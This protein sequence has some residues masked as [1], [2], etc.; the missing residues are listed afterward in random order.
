MQVR[1]VPLQPHAAGR[2]LGL[3]LFF[4]VLLLA[5]CQP[6]IS[7]AA[8]VEVA[9]RV[10]TEHGVLPNAVVKAFAGYDQVTAGKPFM[11][12]GP[13]DGNG[14]FS[15]RLPAGGYYFTAE[16]MYEN[17]QYF[18]FHGNNPIGLTDTNVWL[19]MMASLKVEPRYEDG[20]TGIRGVVTLKGRPLTD[21]Y[22]TVYL[23]TVKTFKGLG[24]MTQT[25][26]EDGTF[27]LSLPV[28]EYVVV[29]KR[30]VDG[31]RLRPL[32]RGDLIGYFPANP[33][34]VRAGKT[35]VVA[36]PTYPKSD[37]ASFVDV[38]EIRTNEYATAD[39]LAAARG[40]GIRGKVLN[41][42]G[43]PLAGVYVLAY[44]TEE[45]VFQMY[46]LSHGSE[47]AARTDRNGDYF[48]PLDQGGSFYVV[49]RDTLGDGPHRDEIYGL[50]Q[51]TPNHTVAFQQGGLVQ[52]I[53][54]IAGTT[55][56]RA[57]MIRE[58]QQV[59]VS[60]A[61]IEND[62]IIDRDTA[63][64]GDI[65]VNGVVSVKRGA[66]LTIEPGTTV[67]FRKLDRDSNGI[68]DGEILIEGRIIA[69]GTAAK[70]IIFTSAAEQPR[71][72][73][74]SY[75][76]VLATETMN[77]FEHCVFEYGYSGMQIH[78]SN[79]EVRNSVFRKNSEGLHFNTVNLIAE[80]NFISGNDV[81]IKFTRLEGNVL[82]ARNEITN[83]GI[84]ILF[85]HQHI[86]AVDFDN[87]HKVLEPPDFIWNN[88]HDNTRY[89]FTMGDRQ[90]IDLPITSNWWGSA[91]REKIADSI[92]DKLDDEELGRAIF[93]PFLAMPQAG[94]GIREN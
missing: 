48:I 76:N 90:N 59:R 74:W 4:T 50:Y 17:E 51:G 85:V 55:M 87:L 70:K 75:V 22:I 63:W 15:M 13:T 14:I 44:K 69:R 39:I 6:G 81:G 62:L 91:D 64:S 92:F 12:S 45:E 61:V 73:D 8:E 11:V 7:R 28:G 25:V 79:A 5:V 49:A 24:F 34:A 38:P 93:E 47:Y 29:G 16:G 83:N 40:A 2:L 68:G 35:A 82:V 3:R 20:E 41:V 53:M 58:Q 54:I 80:N 19:P 21:A 33:V 88:I 56:G 89:N 71:T 43:K 67:R 78:Y 60:D 30:M 77:I 37:R 10:F 72:R 1:Y 31:A 32:Q 27:F 42:N 86:N 36:V 46:H 94:A 57:E 52:D 65:L 18:V 66:T 26:E 23:P 84:G 9:G